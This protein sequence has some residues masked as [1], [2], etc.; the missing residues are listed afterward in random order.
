MEVIND[1]APEETPEEEARRLLEEDGLT[2]LAHLDDAFRVQTEADADWVLN[3]LASITDEITR[4]QTHAQARIIRLVK[5]Y[6]YL[7]NRF[8]F[9]LEDFARRKLAESGGKKKTVNLTHGS[10][11]IRK[12]KRSIKVTDRAEAIEWV[13]ENLPEAIKYDYSK[14]TLNEYILKTGEIPECV[15]IIPEH[16]KFYNGI[17]L[18][19]GLKLPKGMRFAGD[20]QDEE[21]EE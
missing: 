6:H 10:V 1:N 11:F 12:V 7:N 2:D 18:P 19:K 8:T 9:E 5:Q 3:R 17:K 15:E 13:K 4:I 21:D 20:G 16:E 14:S